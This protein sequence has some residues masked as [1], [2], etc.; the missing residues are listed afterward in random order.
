MQV[1]NRT[2]SV[3]KNKPN[4]GYSYQKYLISQVLETVNL[5]KFIT[6]NQEYVSKELTLENANHSYGMGD[7]LKDAPSPQMSQEELD[8]NIEC[9]KKYTYMQGSLAEK[10]GYNQNYLDIN[11]LNDIAKLELGEHE[12][13]KGS[14]KGR[15]VIEREVKVY[16]YGKEFYVLTK[17]DLAKGVANI[18]GAIVNLNQDYIKTY[19]VSAQN[20]ENGYFEINKNKVYFPDTSHIVGDVEK[21]QESF[22]FLNDDEYRVKTSIEITYTV[23]SSF[24]YYI[25][26]LDQKEKDEAIKIYNDTCIEMFNEYVK[27]LLQSYNGEQIVDYLMYQ[28]THL[29]NRS[30][31]PFLHN[32]QQISAV[33]LTADGK[34]MSIEMPAIREKA[35]HQAHDH[36]FKQKFIEKF[37]QRFGNIVEAYDKDYQSIDPKAFGQ[38]IK[39]YRIAYDT[40]SIKEIR[41]NAMVGELISRHI[42]QEKQELKN[43][44]EFE[45]LEIKRKIK[46]LKEKFHNHNINLDDIA[47][48][49]SITHGLDKF[50]EKKLLINIVKEVDGKIQRKVIYHYPSEESDVNK[51]VKPGDLIRFSLVNTTGHKNHYNGLKLSDYLVNDFH[52][53][54]NLEF[55]LISKEETY[56]KQL[57]RM[58]TRKYEDH[59]WSVIKNKKED[60]PMSVKEVKRN[61]LTD[62]M[63]LNLDSSN[64]EKVTSIQRGSEEIFELLT[65]IDP[66]FSYNQLVEQ[67]S[68]TGA[69]KD[70]YKI[71]NLLLEE[72]VQSKSLMKIL[73]PSAVEYN[74]ILDEMKK[75]DPNLKT[76]A[77][78]PEVVYLKTD[79]IAKEKRTIESMR[80]L[81]LN[82][83]QKRHIDPEVFDK[84]L[85]AF[86]AKTEKKLGFEL[87][88]EQIQYIKMFSSNKGLLLVNGSAGTGK[89]FNL[90][91]GYQFIKEL[92]KE[93][94]NLESNFF[95]LAP[96]GKVVSD[97]SSAVNT[98]DNPENV[99]AMTIDKF[100]LDYSLGKLDGKLNENTSI[101][102]DEAA[103][104][105]VR[106]M[107]KL[108]EIQKKH[109]FAIRLIGDAYQLEAV[110]VGSP[111]Q[112]ALEDPILQK[113]FTFLKNIRRQETDS[114]LSIAKE[115]ALTNVSD[116]EIQEYRKNATHIKKAW[117]LIKKN[118]NIKIFDTVEDKVEYEAVSLINTPLE[119]K[120]KAV[121]TS[122]NAQ[123]QLIND[124]T[125]ELRLRGGEL[126][127][128]ES[129]SNFKR[130]FYTNDR[131]VIGKNDEKEGYSNGDFGTI[132]EIKNDKVTVLLDNGKTKVLKQADLN[133]ME[134]RYG[135]S[136]HRSQGMTLKGKTL[137]DEN[138]K[139]GKTISGVKADIIDSPVNNQ[140]LLYV[141]LTRATKDTEVC[142]VR[143]EMERAFASF[144]RMPNK[145]RLV[146]LG[147][148]H[149]GIDDGIDLTTQPLTSNE[150][151]KAFKKELKVAKVNV[152]DYS[153]INLD[154]KELEVM[155]ELDTP[156]FKK[157]KINHSTGLKISKY[158]EDLEKRSDE[159]NL[160]KKQL[161]NSKELENAHH[162]VIEKISEF[163]FEAKEKI[164]NAIKKQKDKFAQKFGFNLTKKPRDKNMDKYVNNYIQNNYNY[165]AEI[166]KAQNIVKSQNDMDYLTPEQYEAKLKEKTDLRV[167][168]GLV[169][170]DIER[171][172]AINNPKQQM[173]EINLIVKKANPQLG[174]N[175]T[176][177]QEE[178]NKLKK[179]NPNINI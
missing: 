53:I 148:L 130:R 56:L 155:K 120:H 15:T 139:P 98:P 16:R 152:E 49:E 77:K 116:S 81:V 150:I 96:S 119:W 124:K 144:E 43:Q 117:E 151:E 91:L 71:A 27:P 47:R 128:E 25:Q 67:I 112:T 22:V 75:K 31:Q 153:R 74:R 169:S 129:F 61:A 76:K 68:K 80:K 110:A 73:D 46:S 113:H 146:D 29:E 85:K 141:M 101:I 55:N 123:V 145:I 12:L 106:N 179:D 87:G 168:A 147:R 178:I 48:V 156:K 160:V 103:M 69:H 26:K 37:T 137:T 78:K 158:F 59:V 40:E 6:P 140:N 149:C 70:V 42:K 21:R 32:H 79:L 118:D 126:N 177:T 2:T 57:E 10:M 9:F 159:N 65:N 131:I 172:I 138:G 41:E 107:D 162:S 4:S 5:D 95:L 109:G 34:Q 24:S 35:W 176:L 23:D 33:G 136:T 86:I 39:D 50:G 174:K 143:N 104:C 154:G 17:D 94:K 121:I 161:L 45:S 132:K 133:R 72:N 64:R 100:V 165:T 114:A 108:M 83:N 99:P 38:E 102:F 97:L 66:Y 11:V 28:F 134:L 135:I 1:G 167:N 14:K 157:E 122:E 54:D 88:E 173:E 82:Y 20:L 105:G 60:L 62:K 142:V 115:L 92:Y 3:Y 18:N 13:T 44:F 58:N 52:A 170:D 125:Q 171:N 84:K 63:K 164:S 111:F 163:T 51:L 19:T 8:H 30:N 93:E 127:I 175:K 89:S 36:I 166:I 7:L 90:N